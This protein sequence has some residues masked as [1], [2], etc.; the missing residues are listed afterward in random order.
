MVRVTYGKTQAFQGYRCFTYFLRSINSY[1]FQNMGKV[2][3]H[4]KGKVWENTNIQKLSVF[5][6][7][8]VKQTHTISKPR[9]EWIPILRSKYGKTQ[10][11]FKFCSTSLELVGTH[12]IPNFW[13]CANSRNMEIFYGKSY[14]SQA[15]V[16]MKLLKLRSY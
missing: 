10:T 3:F 4:S 2:N 8:Y 5:C 6:I 16:F 15:A 11:V 12:T 1:N 9:D 7:F 14:H 13:E